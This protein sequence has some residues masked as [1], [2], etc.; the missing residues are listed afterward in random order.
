MKAHR[1]IAFSVCFAA[2][3]ALFIVG[4]EEDPLSF[5][6]DPG[7]SAKVDGATWTSGNNVDGTVFSSLKSI[8]GTKGDGSSISVN[9]TNVFEVGTF[10]VDDGKFSGSYAKSNNIDEIYASTSGTVEITELNG[11]DIS[12]TFSFTGENSSGETIEVTEGSFKATLR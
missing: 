9:L 2:F 4:C 8:T 6:D 1:H 5:G 7:M 12:G 10:S 3:L 11:N